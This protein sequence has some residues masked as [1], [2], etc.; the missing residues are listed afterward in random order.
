MKK[1]MVM[2]TPQLEA[3]ISLLHSHSCTILGI[4]T[5]LV[6][7][8]ASLC[9]AVMHF[10]IYLCGPLQNPSQGMHDDEEQT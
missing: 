9:S 8:L 4:H 2:G 10:D 6:V 7:S 3:A 5:T 1:V